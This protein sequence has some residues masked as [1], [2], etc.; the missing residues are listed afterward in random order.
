MVHLYAWFHW[1]T[2][3]SNVA[4]FSV[5]LIMSFGVFHQNVN[6]YIFFLFVNCEKWYISFKAFFFYLSLLFVLYLCYL[7][8]REQC[9]YILIGLLWTSSKLKMTWLV[10]PAIR[11]WRSHKLAIN[12]DKS[13]N[14]RTLRYDKGNEES[15]NGY[16]YCFPLSFFGCR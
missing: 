16:D 1:H 11:S 5:N 14:V 3:Y 4:A 9:V 7:Y 8:R 6:L 10:I 12:G 13:E 2:S 15:T